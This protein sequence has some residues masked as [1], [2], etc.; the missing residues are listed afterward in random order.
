MVK[1]ITRSM[2]LVLAAGAAA[3]GQVPRGNLA[4]PA[5]GGGS[6]P[7]GRVFVTGAPFS[8]DQ[9][10][11]RSWRQLDGKEA[12]ESAAGRVYR[13]SRGRVRTEAVGSLTYQGSR[14]KVRVTIEDPVAG[15][16]YNVDEENHVA[17]RTKLG[18]V[19]LR[20]PSDESPRRSGEALGVR[21]M[22]GVAA[23]GTR[24]SLVTGAQRDGRPL[25][26]VAEVWT[27]PEL[28]VDT[29]VSI[30]DTRGAST[31]RFT[32]IDRGEPDPSLF[33]IPVNYRVLDNPSK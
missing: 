13:D 1:R 17:Y 31:T 25:T 30:V 4:G 11:E 33:A 7:A 26:T 19:A 27:S 5:A 18:P 14:G 15:F 9:V 8:G 20:A 10:H 29:L 28:M 2:C 16:R 6:L 32:N 3:S 21:T 12:S 23:Y 22:A 24:G